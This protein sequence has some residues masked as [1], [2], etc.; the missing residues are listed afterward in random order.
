MAAFVESVRDHPAGRYALGLF[1]E[2]RGDP[3]GLP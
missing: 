3:V 1:E 2:R